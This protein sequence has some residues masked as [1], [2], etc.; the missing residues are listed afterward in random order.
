MRYFV[1]SVN[2]YNSTG[3]SRK[4]A[5]LQ[6]VARQFEHV[7]I[8]DHNALLALLKALERLV[9]ACNNSF[10]GKTLKV[11]Y[12]KYSYYISVEPEDK[13]FSEQVIFSM[14]LAPMGLTLF[15][16][17]IHQAVH[18]DLKAFDDKK[19]LDAYYSKPVDDLLDRQKGG[20]A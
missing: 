4:G 14:Q 8:G 7:V 6:K 11:C 20:Q 10:R 19:L 18:S 1:E 17:N 9:A 15:S 13:G 2:T 3:K 16:S 12:N 5:I